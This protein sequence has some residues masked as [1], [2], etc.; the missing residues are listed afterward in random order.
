MAKRLELQ[1]LFEEILGSRN[2]YFQPPP[3][4]KMNYPAIVYALETIENMHADNL[5]YK[6]DKV[7]RVTVITYDPDSEIIDK[8]STFPKCRFA[9][10]FKSDNLNHYIFT[11]Y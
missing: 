5:V 10:H 11:L 7:Y 1:A 3:T 6:Q 8:V 2:V 9:R 4:I